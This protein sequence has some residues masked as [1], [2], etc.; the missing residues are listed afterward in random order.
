MDFVPTLFELSPH[1]YL[2]A[3][4]AGAAMLAMWIYLR[5]PDAGPSSVAA[6]TLHMVVSVVGAN[7]VAPAVLRSGASREAVFAATFVVVLPLL[8]YIFLSAIWLI[9]FGQAT[10]SRYSR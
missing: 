6:I 10:L 2:V 8:V 4:V 9:R 5:V 1:A 7:L 3:F